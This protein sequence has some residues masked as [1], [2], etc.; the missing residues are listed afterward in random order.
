[1]VQGRGCF[2]LVPRLGYTNGWMVMGWT[3]R[4]REKIRGLSGKKKLGYI[5]D[6]YKLWIIGFAALILFAVYM[7]G[8]YIHGN[9]ENHIYVMCVNTFADIG[10]RSEFW[11]GY[12]DFCGVDPQEENVVFDVENYFDMSKS[13]VTGN[14]YYEKAVVLI[15]SGTMDAIV[16]EK[17]NLAL[18]G[19]SGRLTDLR[20]ER[21]RELAE[22]YEDRLITIRHTN[23]DG[24]TEEIPVGID[25]SDSLLAAEG[26]YETCALGIATG[27]QHVEAVGEFLD[28]IFRRSE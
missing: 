26:E 20:N 19:Q 8:S 22:K 18:L 27:A 4:E 2:S 13:N 23:E 25:I 11:Q 5:W 9:R 6:Y 15:D 17:E 16:L 21:T 3:D 12:A 14:H 28:Y 7:V 24:V 1:M 10:E